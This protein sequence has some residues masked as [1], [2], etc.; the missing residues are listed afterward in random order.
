MTKIF[1]LIR[2]IKGFGAWNKGSIPVSSF[3]FCTYKNLWKALKI[4]G[5]ESFG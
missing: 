1:V 4:K 3:I 2:K 5:K